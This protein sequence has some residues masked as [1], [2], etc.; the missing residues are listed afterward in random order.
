MRLRF[1]LFASLEL[2]TCLLKNFRKSYFSI[3][4]AYSIQ[5]TK[6]GGCRKKREKYVLPCLFCF[7]TLNIVY[8]LV[9]G[10]GVTHVFLCCA[11]EEFFGPVDICLFFYF[12]L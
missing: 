8:W 5:Q 4:P 9:F 3:Y 7:F 11:D 12:Y 10:V 6:N 2:V 1:R